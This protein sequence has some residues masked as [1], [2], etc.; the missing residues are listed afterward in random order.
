MVNIAFYLKQ[1]R[2]YLMYKLNQP[3]P[4]AVTIRI[5]NKCNLRCTFCEIWKLNTPDELNRQH[6]FTIA[7]E[8]KRIG[9]PYVTITGGEPLLR[10]DIE[11][12]GMYFSQKGI[13]T[14]LNTNG[15]LITKERAIRLCQAYQY[16]RISLDGIGE[17]HN[18]IR[19]TRSAYSLVCQGIQNLLNVRIKKTKVALHF[20]VT[21][22]N[23]SELNKII[24]AFKDKV[25]SISLM[26]EF[27]YNENKLMLNPKTLKKLAIMSRRLRRVG[28]SEQ[29]PEFLRDCSYHKGK[30][31]CDAGRL[32]FAIGPQGNV[33]VCSGRRFI[34]G[35][36]LQESF[37][38]IWKR[39]I[40]DETNRKIMNCPG[41]Y[42]RCTTEIS[43]L[44]RK[45]PLKLLLEAKRI[46]LT[47]RY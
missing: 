13:L 25:D 7:D 18:K 41:C 46:L 27:F 22:Q 35:N 2:V 10:D 20:V 39:G 26:P 32:Y 36:V 31:L 1:L 6:L 4:C 44:F 16:I 42:F 21:N 23:I 33:S 43:M 34:I 5:T 45:S 12:I 11:D 24:L 17:A 38:S 29:S 8:L 28:L 37:Y 9:V 40:N 19:G 14:N 47:Y 15:T 3:I 30:E